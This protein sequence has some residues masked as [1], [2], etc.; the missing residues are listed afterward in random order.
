[1]PSQG[2][3]TSDEKNKVKSTLSSTSK[4]LSVAIA[5]IYYAYPDEKRW[6]YSGQQGALAFVKDKG[7]GFPYLRLID[8][9][10]TRS[11]IWE[12]ELYEGMQ[13]ASDRPFFHSFPGDVCDKIIRR[14]FDLIFALFR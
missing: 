3:I 4:I 9:Q 5:R 6:M 10:G 13:L 1:M 8:L 11:V 2:A 7:K 12:H 14:D